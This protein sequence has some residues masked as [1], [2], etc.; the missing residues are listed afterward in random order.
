MNEI[1]S[2]P[3]S[4]SF[5]LWKGKMDFVELLDIVINNSKRDI[6]VENKMIKSVEKM[7][8]FDKYEKNKGKL[9]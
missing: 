5:Y 1:N 2:I 8:I 3:G 7:N 4:Y 6:F 9:K